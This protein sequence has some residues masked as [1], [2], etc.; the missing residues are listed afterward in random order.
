MFHRTIAAL[1]L[2]TSLSRLLLNRPLNQRVVLVAVVGES[3]VG[4]ALDRDGNLFVSNYASSSISK[5]DCKNNVV[6]NSYITGLLG[7]SF[8]AFDSR[9]N[10]YVSTDV[11]AIRQYDNFGNLL[12]PMFG[13]KL[14]F[15]PAGISFGVEDLLYVFDYSNGEVRR[16]S[17]NGVLDP[18]PF[19]SGLTAHIAVGIAFDFATQLLYVPDYARNRILRITPTGAITTFANIDEPLVIVVGNLSSAAFVSTNNPDTVFKVSQHG[20]VSQYASVNAPLGLA[21]A[22]DGDLFVSNYDDRRVVKVTNR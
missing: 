21:L 9:G 12:T 18:T 7:A 17:A 14:D 2:L 10:L 3:P 5:V 6:N 16:I 4:L 11:A 15:V 1:V 13:G 19:V 8:I 22:S 20:G